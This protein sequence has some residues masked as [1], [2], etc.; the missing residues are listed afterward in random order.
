LALVVGLLYAILAPGRVTMPPL[1]FDRETLRRI[2]RVAWRVIGAI[3]ALLAMIL[4]APAVVR[5]LMASGTRSIA[6]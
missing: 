3:A 2:A 5:L 6:R 1:G 4:A